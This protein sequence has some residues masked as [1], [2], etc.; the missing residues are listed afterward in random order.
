MDAP[1]EGLPAHLDTVAVN[2]ANEGIP[3]CAIARILAFPAENVYFSLKNALDMG[4]ICEIP[5]ADWPPTAKRADRVP[6]ARA[7]TDSDLLFHARQVFKLTKLE[8]GFVVVLLRHDRVEKEKLHHVIEQQRAQR[9]HQP[10]E[11]ESTDPKMV[12]V[13]ICKLRKKLKTLDPEFVIKT[14]WGGGYHIAS[15]VKT[16]MLHTLNGASHAGEPDSE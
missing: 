4:A 6:T 15:D 8:A 1:V 11:L 13:I 9:A 10:I 14:I 2:A 5:K 16:K 3:V 12:D 7:P